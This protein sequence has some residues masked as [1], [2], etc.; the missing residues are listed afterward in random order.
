MEGV[1]DNHT[2]F[3]TE[4]AECFG[5]PNFFRS[6]AV[7]PELIQNPWSFTK[8]AYLDNPIPSLFKERLFVVL[9]RLRPVPCCIVRHTI[10]LLGCGRPA[11]DAHVPTERVADVIQLLKQPAPW[12][13]DMSLSVPSSIAGTTSRRPRSVG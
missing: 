5:M 12:G 3:Q 2:F 9:S 10:F 7:A 13:Q 11:T 8:S 4:V 6:A 1:S